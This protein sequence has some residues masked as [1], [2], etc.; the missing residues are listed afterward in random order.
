M[1]S[2]RGLTVTEALDQVVESCGRKVEP[3]GYKRPNAAK[4]Q[5]H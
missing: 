1:A 5:G 2:H 3:W 4:D